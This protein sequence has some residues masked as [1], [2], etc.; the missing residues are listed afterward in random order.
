MAPLEG[1][2]W[3]GLNFP[4]LDTLNLTGTQYGKE[5]KLRSY[6]WAP[7]G[8]RK[9]VV[10]MMHGYGSNCAIQAV[11]AKYFVEKGYEVFGMDMRGMGDS[12][13]ERGFLD[14]TDVV[15]NDYWQMIFSACKKF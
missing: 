13:G 9:A 4:E 2:E 8:E 15:Y 3:R 6:H 12:E 14:S 7:V 11:I 5:I 1:F 10:F